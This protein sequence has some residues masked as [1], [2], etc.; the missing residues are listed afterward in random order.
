LR[1]GGVGVHSSAAPGALPSGLLATAAGSITVGAAL[2]LA[3]RRSRTSMA[4]AK[5][6]GSKAPA[7]DIAEAKAAPPPPP[8]FDPAVQLGATQ[9][10]GFFDPLGFAK[11]GDEEGFRKLRIAEVKHGRVA[12][13]AAVG[14]VIQHFVQFPG[15]DQIPKGLGAVLSPPGT[16]GFAALFLVSGA[17]ELLLWKDDPNQKVDSIGDYG[18]P[19]QLGVGDPLGESVD[20]KNRELNNGRAAMFAALGIIV[21]E[22]ATGK[23]AVQQ[24]G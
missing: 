7:G 2:S 9:P 1:G 16:Y 19:L 14:A 17:L 15:F 10:L 18:N 4:A 5:E 13:M 20:M 3:G 24:L 23:D 12:M 21:A 6:T 11:K 22:L 8:P